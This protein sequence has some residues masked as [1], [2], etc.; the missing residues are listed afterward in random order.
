MKGKLSRMRFLE[1]HRSSS[2]SCDT[3]RLKYRTHSEFTHFCP[4]SKLVRTSSLPM[5]ITYVGVTVSHLSSAQIF[6]QNA[7]Q[8]FGYR[9][10][11]RSSSQATF[12][13]NAEPDFFLCQDPSRGWPSGTHVT[14]SV[15]TSVQVDAFYTAALAA[16]GR[17]HTAPRYCGYK[18][19]DYSASI[20]DM[21]KNAVEV[22][23]STPVGS[24]TSHRD[25]STNG[26]SLACPLHGLPLQTIVNNSSATMP[27]A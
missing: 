10:L 17:T 11:R 4:Y 22:V 15:G 26:S 3:A 21:D 23:C 20:I 14:L 13:T 16:G 9:C 5:P 2:T 24:K 19:A 27:A 7:L 18:H 6:C 8:P 1:S 25:A 12:G